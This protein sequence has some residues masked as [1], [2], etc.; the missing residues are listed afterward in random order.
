[1][2]K[3]VKKR[4][5]SFF[6]NNLKLVLTNSARGSLGDSFL[7][8]LD[9][10]V[11]KYTHVYQIK[12]GQLKKQ[13]PS[14][15]VALFPLMNR[16]LYRSNFAQELLF[17]NGVHVSVPHEMSFEGMVLRTKEDDK[18][19]IKEV[20]AYLSAYYR[21]KIEEETASR[22]NKLSSELGSVM[23]AFK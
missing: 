16:D 8:P 18:D 7:V 20:L 14:S 2:I 4:G 12:D 6:E 1:M 15:E 9:M 19:A 3:S 21:L 13:L 17:D 23:D 5:L 22:L 10:L 11:D